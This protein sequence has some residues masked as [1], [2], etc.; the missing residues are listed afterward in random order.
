VNQRDVKVKGSFSIVSFLKIFVTMMHQRIGIVFV[1][2]VCLPL[3]GDDM[4]DAATLDDDDDEQPKQ[5]PESLRIACLIPS[6][7]DICRALGLSQYVVGITHECEAPPAPDDSIG[8]AVRILTEDKLPSTLSQGEIHEI[9]QENSSKHAAAAAAAC[10]RTQGADGTEDVEELPPSLYPID[11][12]AFQEAA[13]TVVITQDLCNVCA[14]SS[15]SVEQAL[16]SIQQEQQHHDSSPSR[17]RPTIVSLSPHSLQDVLENIETVAAACGVPQRGIRLRHT[18]QERLADVRRIVQQ[19]QG[20]TADAPTRV[21]LLEWLDPPFDGGHWIPDMMRYAGL[22]MVHVGGAATA[23]AAEDSSSAAWKKSSQLTWD[24]IEKSDPDAVV[25]ACCGFD[26]DRNHRDAVRAASNLAPL[27]ASQHNNSVW[28]V[29]GDLYFARPGPHLVE[30]VVILALC[31]HHRQQGEGESNVAQALRTLDWIDWTAIESAYRRVTFDDT[32]ATSAASIE[33]PVMDVEDYATVHDRA[34]ANRESFYADPDTGYQVFTEHAHLQRG[35]CCGSG[36]R[37]CPYGHENLK[38]KV[39][40]IQQPAILTDDSDALEMLSPQR[41]SHSKVLFFSGGKDSFLAIRAVVKQAQEWARSS[42]SPS[43]GEPFGLILL[44]TF[45]ATSR[46]IAHQE[47][48]VATAVRQAQRLGLMLVGVPMHRASS[49]SYV[50]RVRRALDLLEGKRGF[51]VSALVFGDLHLA[52]VVEWRKQNMPQLGPYRLEFPLYL[53]RY[54]S[55][56]Q[57]LHDSGIQCVVT[58]STVDASVVQEGDTYNNDLRRRLAD[59]SMDVFGENGEFH[60]EAQV[61][62]VPRNRALGLVQ[63]E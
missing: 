47:M 8:P 62:T 12:R 16:Q 31:A 27:R 20:E 54:D 19:C 18:L 25:V 56:L 28:A 23:T 40:K 51:R 63:D 53:E 44:T 22:D 41:H 33:P 42:P 60:T 30:G 10:Q 50:D 13:P 11:R 5:P 36:C 49:E 1:A 7:T 3:E 34:C 55:L 24:L 37:H 29:H 35:K 48:P 59:A 15:S 2:N 61:W 38:D 39:G 26:L 17:R 32:T 57:D 14:P 9:V 21:L 58:A 4:T 6:A 45:D 52:H 46:M 43:K